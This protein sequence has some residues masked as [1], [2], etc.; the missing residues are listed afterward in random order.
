MDAGKRQ[1]KT[2]DEYIKTFPEQVQ[3]I[4]EKIRRTIRK[5]APEASR[6]SRKNSRDSRDQ[7]ARCNFLWTYPSRMTL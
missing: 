6:L 5:A 4:L 3:I 2:M 7:G 1:F